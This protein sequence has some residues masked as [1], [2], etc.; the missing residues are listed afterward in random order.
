MK[1]ILCFMENEAPMNNIEDLFPTTWRVLV[2]LDDD[3]NISFMAQ[4]SFGTSE[5]VASRIL[6]M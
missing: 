3:H 1:Q 6:H 4:L 5:S 2:D